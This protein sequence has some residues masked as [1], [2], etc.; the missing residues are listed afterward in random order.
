M[1]RERDTL[2]AKLKDMIEAKETAT[3]EEPT[4]DEDTST[5]L[6]TSWTSTKGCHGRTSTKWTTTARGNQV[7]NYET[8]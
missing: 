5:S 3:D 2:Q 7:Y 8:K 4:T 6:K 1:R